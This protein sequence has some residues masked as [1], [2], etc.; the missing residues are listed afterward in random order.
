MA[1][2]K[3]NYLKG[4]KAPGG[5]AAAGDYYTHRDG[6][7]RSQRIW[8]EPSGEK[9][10]KWRDIRAEIRDE[11]KEHKYTYRIVLSQEQ[12]RFGPEHYRE[13]V[14]AAGLENSYLVVHENTEN[15]HAHAIAFTDKRINR[16]DL[17]AMRGRMSELEQELGKSAEARVGISRDIDQEG[18]LGR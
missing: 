13:V 18:G 12:G 11:A 10:E 15:Q 8:Y 3:V 6:P 17:A 2:V 1:V 14:Q 7:D 16:K 4:K 5:A 9:I